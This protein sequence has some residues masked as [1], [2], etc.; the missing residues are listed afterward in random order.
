MPRAPSTLLGVEPQ[1]SPGLATDPLNLRVTQPQP[2]G[3]RVEVRDHSPRDSR[4]TRAAEGERR[5][6]TVAGRPATPAPGALDLAMPAPRLNTDTP[7]ASD[8]QPFSGEPTLAGVS[9][10]AQQLARVAAAPTELPAVA[11]H[12]PLHSPGFAPELSARVS[13][14]AGQGVERA[15]LQLNPADMGPV[16][17]RIAV[18]GQQAQVSFHAAQP[19]TRQALEQS[20][21]DLAAALRAGGLTLTGG[22]VF[23]QSAGSG[24]GGADPR[25]GAALQRTGRI[26]STRIGF[27]IETP[28]PRANAA[29]RRL[30][31]LDT[32]V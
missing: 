28:A 20:L 22:G 32:Y 15:E 6:E 11:L 13:L 4:A 29:P 9:G 7:Q 21:P 25:E 2:A 27:D 26:A 8:R 12:A 1:Q 23:Q 24:G 5:A 14:L 19:D 18:E 17:V 10:F 3:G 16:S 30:G 31:L